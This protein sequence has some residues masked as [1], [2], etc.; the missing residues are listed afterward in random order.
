MLN[1]F[2]L[3]LLKTF[4]MPKK[5]LKFDTFLK[6]ETNQM[7][8]LPNTIQPQPHKKLYTLLL[9]HIKSQLESK[10]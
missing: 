2:L 8:F 10:F 6:P 9:L 4:V 7:Q 3:V 1:D 5:I